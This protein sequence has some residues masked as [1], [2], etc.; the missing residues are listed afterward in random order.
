MTL[1]VKAKTERSDLILRESVLDIFRKFLPVFQWE[2]SEGLDV[3]ER[4][5]LEIL[6]KACHGEF[7]KLESNFA[8]ESG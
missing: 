6:D 7:E 8:S 3:E 1:V 4:V 5:E 2:R